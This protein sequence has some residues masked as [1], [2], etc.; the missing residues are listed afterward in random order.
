MEAGRHIL[1][2]QATRQT[3]QE[4]NPGQPLPQRQGIISQGAIGT[5]PSPINY[6]DMPPEDKGSG[7]RLDLSSQAGC[8]I[9]WLFRD[10]SSKTH[11]HMARKLLFLKF[12]G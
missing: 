11:F 2:C 8:E 7:R 10:P 4:L 1:G 5:F 12:E 6:C 3:E 9:L